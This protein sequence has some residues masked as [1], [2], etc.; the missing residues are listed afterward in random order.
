MAG[1]VFPQTSFSSSASSSPPSSHGVPA[2]ASDIHTMAHERRSAVAGVYP[3][4]AAAAAAAAAATACCASHLTA[5]RRAD[6]FD[7]VRQKLKVME[8]VVV[9][10]MCW[11]RQ[12]MHDRCCY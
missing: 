5:C 9:A 7:I 1:G 8:Q 11:K 3:V 2:L 6:A 12:F 10:A 4:A